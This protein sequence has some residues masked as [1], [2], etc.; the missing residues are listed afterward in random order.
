MPSR[1]RRSARGAIL[2]VGP[3]V[4][5]LQTGLDPVGA[6]EGDRPTREPDHGRGPLV[7]V[8]LGAGDT[9]VVVDHRV[10]DL[11]TYAQRLSAPGRKRSPMTAWPG[12]VKRAERLVPICRRSPGQGHS[13]RRTA[14]FGAAGRRERPRRRGQRETVAWGM[15]VC[16]AI[17]RGPQPVLRRSSQMR[18]WTS[19]PVGEGRRCGAEERS[20]RQ[21]RSAR[22]PSPA[23]R[24][25][26]TQAWAVDLVRPSSSTSATSRVNAGRKLGV[27][28]KERGEAR[29]NIRC[30]AEALRDPKNAEQGGAADA[31]SS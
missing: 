16:D 26:Q 2:H 30:P 22:L 29:I 8:Q 1:A 23:R 31:R 12:M 6:E 9:G 13:K 28:L 20:S 15:P 11:V 7:A 19:A 27:L 21:L 24:Y 4:V 25:L 3:G 10:G 18:S 17:R 5:G 14:S